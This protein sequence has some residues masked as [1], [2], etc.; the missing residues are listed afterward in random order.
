MFS[1]LHQC[2]CGV[3][4]CNTR[5]PSSAL[6]PPS[7][8]PRVHEHRRAFPL[9]IAWQ[10]RMRGLHTYSD[11]VVFVS[12]RN[13]YTCPRPAEPRLRCTA[14][15]LLRA[16]RWATKHTHTPPC[17]M[18]VK[19]IAGRALGL[20]TLAAPSS[21]PRTQAAR[22]GASRRSRVAVT[23]VAM[24]DKRTCTASSHSRKSGFA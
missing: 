18:Q 12:C 20:S 11:T 16:G 19:A 6:S 1:S 22:L 2:R 4:L 3:T 17:A 10:H 14:P 7:R 9:G 24:E 21:R 13:R 5:R 15:E 8:P 23:A